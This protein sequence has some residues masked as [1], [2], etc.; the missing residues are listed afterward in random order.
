[1]V[2][3]LRTSRQTAEFTVLPVYKVCHKIGSDYD[4]GIDC[5]GVFLWRFQYL[6]GL[7]VPLLYT[8]CGQGETSPEGFYR[9]PGFSP[10]GDCY[11]DQPEFVLELKRVG[12]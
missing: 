8:S 12:K 2:A 9:G 4:D 6:E 11:G 7:G 1:M 3:G 5:P 10:T